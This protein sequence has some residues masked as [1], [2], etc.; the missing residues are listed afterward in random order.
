M[1]KLIDADALVARID[2]M[3]SESSNAV[4]LSAIIAL[5]VVKGTLI[6]DM[7]DASEPL[8]KRI[9]ELEEIVQYWERIGRRLA[10]HDT[11]AQ[12]ERIISS[13]EALLKGGQDD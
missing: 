8:R 2:S 11:N 6:P 13:A 4:S 9:K 7:P 12:L 10:N 3:M 5:A 1:S